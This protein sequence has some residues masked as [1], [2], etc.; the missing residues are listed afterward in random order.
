MI[1]Y[2]SNAL[3][4]QFEGIEANLAD[5]ELVSIFRISSH[6][7]LAID[8]VA[9]G[10]A[11]T[12]TAKVQHKIGEV[13]TDLKSVSVTT[14]TSSIRVLAEDAADLALLPLRT[15]G[16]VLLTSDGSGAGTIEKVVATQ[17]S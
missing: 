10:V 13:W 4:Q 5:A 11:G 2:N 9:S 12:I 17:Y 15:S 1:G 7:H 3:K 16:R 14:G 8:I 6:G